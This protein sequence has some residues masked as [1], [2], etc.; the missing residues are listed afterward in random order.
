MEIEGKND[1]W[2]LAVAMGIMGIGGFDH[3][4]D[5]RYYLYRVYGTL[6]ESNC[7]TLIDG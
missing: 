2:A 4:I 6:V 5:S 1:I 7:N 3:N